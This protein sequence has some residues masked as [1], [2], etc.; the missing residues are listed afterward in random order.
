MQPLFE[1]PTL[2]K[3][4]V[5]VQ[6]KEATQE[7]DV[8]EVVTDPDL[9]QEIETPVPTPI[10]IPNQKEKERVKTKKAN[11]DPDLVPLATESHKTHAVIAAVTITLLEPV[12]NVRMTKR[13][14][15]QNQ[16]T[17]KQTSTLPSTRQP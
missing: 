16:P 4:K 6:K 15:R 14:V 3:G 12:T 2:T 8:A 17:S 9:T 11:K 5:V 1:H 10:T 13:M 7:K